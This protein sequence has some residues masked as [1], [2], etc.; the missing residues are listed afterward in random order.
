[1]PFHLLLTVLAALLLFPAAASAA[2]VPASDGDAL[3][4]LRLPVANDGVTPLRQVLALGLPDTEVL[5]AWLEGHNGRVPLAELRRDS[6]FAARPIATRILALPIDLA[7]GEQAEVVLRY[8]THAN[9]PVQPELM[10]VERFQEALALEAL[11]DGVILGL[12]GTLALLSALQFRA[13]RRRAMLVFAVLALAMMAFMAQFQGYLFAYVWPR[14]GLW[15]QMVP[16]ILAVLVQATHALFT[17]SV[18]DMGRTPGF[19]RIYVVYLGLLPVTLAIYQETGWYWPGMAMA[20]AY[21][22]LSLA[23]GIHFVRRG[24][25]GAGHYL[26]GT[27]AYGLFSHVLFGLG[28]AGLD[29][30]VSPFVFPRIGYVAEALFFT[31]A[32]AHQTT[33]LRHQIEEALHQRLAEARLLAHAEA[34]KNRALMAVQHGRMQLAATGH[35]LAQPLSSIRFALAALRHQ[36]A[37]AAATG[38]IDRAL[39]Y[40]ESL[41]RSLIDDAKRGQSD[42]HWRLDAGDL[43]SAAWD[44]HQA[45]A[46]ARGLDLRVRPSSCRVVASEGVV[47]RILDNLIGNALRYCPSG[48]ILLGARRRSDGIELQVVDTGPGFDTHLRDRL[49]APF[50]QSGRLAQEQDGHGLGLHIV[51]TLCETSGYRLTIRSTP[52]RGSAFGIVL[53]LA[54]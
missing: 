40:T 22:P 13:T 39:D 52:G 12:L 17:L 3:H 42:Q 54:E 21:V 10:P 44:R 20:M 11:A 38:H 4:W 31:L 29:S 48:S 27:L 43:L 49:L 53:P 15:N 23:A 33:A 34:E 45:A 26:A 7:A 5:D 41:L 2:K 19:H 35:D 50:S 24:A 32:L 47:A 16:V 30:G 51:R 9:T 18:F 6:P 1:M 14:H 36:D 25:P 8:R 46:A 28:V 37:N